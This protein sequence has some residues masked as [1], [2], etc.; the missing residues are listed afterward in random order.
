MRSSLYHRPPP[1]PTVNSPSYLLTAMS[2]V[3][4]C[5]SSGER[6]LFVLM[7]VLTPILGYV[8]A[9]F[10]GSLTRVANSNNDSVGPAFFIPKNSVLVTSFGG[11]RSIYHSQCTSKAR[12]MRTGAHGWLRLAKI[13]GLAWGDKL[14][15]KATIWHGNVYQNVHLCQYIQRRIF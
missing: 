9:A 13:R 2:E 10:Y 15:I 7:L 11:L 6:T 4:H 8:T 1:F 5:R 14:R 3:L 12:G